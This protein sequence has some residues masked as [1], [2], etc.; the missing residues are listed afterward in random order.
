MH[1][2]YRGCIF[3]PYLNPNAMKIQANTTLK[4]RSIGD[5]NCIFE[6]KVHSRTEK[7]CVITLMGTT[8]RTKIYT[9]RDGVEYLRPYKY[10]MAP[11]FFAN[12]KL[13]F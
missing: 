11:F 5:Y 9:D 2:I 6:A 12:D 1:W 8:Q 13:N 7:S 10:S 4:T 3:E